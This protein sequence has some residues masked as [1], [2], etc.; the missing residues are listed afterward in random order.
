MF[1][2]LERLEAS[3]ERLA[4]RSRDCSLPLRNCKRASSDCSR[5]AR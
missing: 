3:I 2:Y 1:A 5:S 4:Q